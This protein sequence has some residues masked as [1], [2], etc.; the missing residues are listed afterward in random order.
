MWE[1]V[2]WNVKSD[3]PL[4]RRRK[5][6]IVYEMLQ[7][8]AAATIPDTVQCTM[9]IESACFLMKHNITFSFRHYSPS[10]E[11]NRFCTLR[12][13]SLYFLRASA[14]FLGLKLDHISYWIDVKFRLNTKETYDLCTVASLLHHFHIY[15]FKRNIP[16]ELSIVWRLSAFITKHSVYITVLDNLTW[17]SPT[18]YIYVTRIAHHQHPPT[19]ATYED[20][21]F[22]TVCSGSVNE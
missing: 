2:D 11:P 10:F 3:F 13:S 6:N 4:L 17:I 18:P 16:H 22:A 14:I 12:L 20:F 19:N 9:Y 1:I 8:Y 5:K 15:D 21:S 7:T